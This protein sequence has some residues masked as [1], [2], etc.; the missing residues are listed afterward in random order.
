ML[1]LHH[2]VAVAE[3]TA[4]LDIISG[5]KFLFGLGQGY[6]DQEFQ[7]FGVRKRDRR[8]RMAEVIRR[9]RSEENVDFEGEFVKLEGV[10][11]A[12]KPIQQP[13]PPIFV[14]ADLLETVVRVPEVG[15]H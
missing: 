11:I 15:D 4:T 9:L 2:P 12:P 5:G 3:Q 14:G 1:P 6:R 7:S 10:T 13:R 8:R